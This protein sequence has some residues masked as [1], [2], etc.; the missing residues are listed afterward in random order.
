MRIDHRIRRA[1]MSGAAVLLAFGGVL[2]GPSTASYA[3]PP[4]GFEL[5]RQNCTEIVTDVQTSGFDCADLWAER[6]GS[7]YEIEGGNETYCES[8]VPPF[9][10]VAC[11]S[12]IEH[13]GTGWDTTPSISQTLASTQQIC[14]MPPH[15]DC[16]A[17]DNFHIAPSIVLIPGGGVPG[18]PATTCP[19]WG[20]SVDVSIALPGSGDAAY[21]HEISTTLDD[22]SC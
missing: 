8:N 13:A 18:Q 2:V 5:V 20:D 19:A 21:L 12:I 17:G 22:F 11:K 9:P 16:G 3:G 15:S 10:L 7:G 14:G 1:A 4:A 6:D